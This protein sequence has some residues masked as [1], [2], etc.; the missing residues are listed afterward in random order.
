MESILK[1]KK[2][3]NA[4]ILFVA[5]GIGS[6]VVYYYWSASSYLEVRYVPVRIMILL[7]VYI[8]CHL[9]KRTLSKEQLWYDW[10]YYIGLVSVAIPVFIASPKNSAIL[11]PAVQIGVMFLVIPLLIEGYLITKEKKQ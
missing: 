1:Y 10:L 9:L 3:I 5:L 2:Q 8:L 4:L 11:L 6:L 7:V